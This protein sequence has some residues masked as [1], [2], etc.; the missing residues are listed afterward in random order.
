MKN[1]EPSYVDT[2]G[3]HK[4]VRIMQNEEYSDYWAE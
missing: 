1:Y 4:A 3:L 2:T